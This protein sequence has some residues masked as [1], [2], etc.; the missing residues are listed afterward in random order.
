MAEFPPLQAEA[1]FIPALLPL[2]LFALLDGFYLFV[3]LAVVVEWV[4]ALFDVAMRNVGEVF[5][6]DVDGVDA[7]L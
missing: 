6:D 3:I 4:R 2:L 7:A 5:G 1:I